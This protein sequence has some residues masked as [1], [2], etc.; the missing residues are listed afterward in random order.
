M[1]ITGTPR[2]SSMSKWGTPLFTLDQED[3]NMITH[4]SNPESNS[5]ILMD[6]TP[7]GASVGAERTGQCCNSANLICDADRFF[8]EGETA[9]SSGS[10][11][12]DQIQVSKSP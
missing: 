1:I 12:S 10:R 4:P 6:D 5:I 3:F 8:Q 9:E 7:P 11:E 2:S